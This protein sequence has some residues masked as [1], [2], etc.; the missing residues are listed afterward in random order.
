MAGEHGVHRLRRHRQAVLGI[1]PVGD[2]R[3]LGRGHAEEQARLGRGVLG[4]ADD[5]VRAADVIAHQ[6]HVVALDLRLR[7]VR[8]LQE[9]QVVDGD[10]LL[11]ALRGQQQRVRRVGEVEGRADEAV[12]GR[13][14]QAMPRVVERRAPRAGGPRASRSRASCA[15]GSGSGRTRRRGRSGPGAPA[16]A[17]AGR[18][19]GRTSRPPWA[20]RGRVSGRGRCSC[21]SSGMISSPALRMLNSAV[22]LGRPRGASR[23]KPEDRRGRDGL[24]RAGGGGVPRRERQHRRLRGQRRGQGRRAARAARS[25]STSPGLEEMIP[26]NV[27][28]ERL[29]FTT[30]LRRRSRPATSSSSPWARRRTR[31]APRTCA[32]C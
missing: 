7:H 1:D 20:W 5:A 12:E 2:H 9:E 16:R 25:R 22:A 10:D 15:P 18:G 26:R 13:P 3:D 32:T 27:R 29:R 17:A 23:R 14:F 28:E 24:R 30:D 21:G 31:T 8:V 19:R 6:R 11:R 4:D